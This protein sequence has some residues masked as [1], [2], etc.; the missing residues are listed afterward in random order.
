MDLNSSWEHEGSCRGKER[1]A[2]A[3][4]GICV[5]LSPRLLLM[6]CS[7]SLY[8]MTACCPS[9]MSVPQFSERFQPYVQY[10]LQ[11]KQTMAYAREQQ[12]TN[13]LFQAFV[14][15]GNGV[16]GE[17]PGVGLRQPGQPIS[18]WVQGRREPA[19]S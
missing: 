15:V 14:Q 19:D 1:S 5:R 9:P 12:D 10:C 13:P 4:L 2:V 7:Q 18:S 17:G 6:F 11:V 3:G 8:L 16:P